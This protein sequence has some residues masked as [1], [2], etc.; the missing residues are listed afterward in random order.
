MSEMLRAAS[1]F[2]GRG[3]VIPS[4]EGRTV[5]RTTSFSPGETD[6]LKRDQTTCQ[7]V[8]TGEFTDNGPTLISVPL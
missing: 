4:A 3:D 2:R 1:D 8:R 6:G 5:G 7:N